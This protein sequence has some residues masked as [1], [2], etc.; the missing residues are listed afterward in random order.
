MIEYAK[1]TSFLDFSFISL[2]LEKNDTLLVR[3]GEDKN[4][5]NNVQCEKKRPK[6]SK[7]ISAAIPSTKGALVLLVSKKNV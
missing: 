5:V 2:Y 6:I 1:R 7:T 3:H 4:P